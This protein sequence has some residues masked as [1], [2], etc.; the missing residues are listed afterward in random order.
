MIVKNN[1]A[2]IVYLG[3]GKDAVRL[4]PG[5]NL[6]DAEAWAE[7]MKNKI[8][9]LIVKE[10]TVEVVDKKA[11]DLS[12]LA[13]AKAAKIVSQIYD[14]ELLAQLSEDEQRAA[15]LKALG[16]QKKLM[17]LPTDEDVKKFD[18]EKA[19]SAA[20]ASASSEE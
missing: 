13:P 14:P 18:A 5:N 1:R 3:N 17:E 2:S 4:M 16:A 15:V 7:A 19:Q 11:D 6:V 9:K 12:D 10:G 8:A 20:S